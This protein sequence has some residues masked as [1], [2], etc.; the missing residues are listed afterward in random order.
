M[1]DVQVS[2]SSNWR[3]QEIPLT[4]R[5]R[6]RA[7]DQPVADELIPGEFLK[8]AGLEIVDARELTL[9]ARRSTMAASTLE[10]TARPEKD[11]HYVLAI[12]HE[13]GALTFHAPS[14][15]GAGRRGKATAEN[16]VR[17]RVE[18]RDAPSGGGRRGLASRII[19]TVL[20]KVVGKVADKALSWFAQ[21][22]ERRTWKKKGLSEGVF[23]VNRG[24]LVN[25]NLKPARAADFGPTGARCLLLIH[26]TFSNATASFAGLAA[27][28]RPDF[29]DEIERVYD[30]RIFAFNHF[31]VSK[32]PRD[33]VVDLLK[34]LPARSHKFDVITHSRGGLV[35]RTLTEMTNEF[36]DAATR[37]RLGHAVLVAAPN[38][39]TP[40]ATPDRWENYVSWMANVA[41]VLPDNPLS[42]TMDFVSEA[43]S[44]L[45]KRIPGAA[46]GVASM[47]TE[48]P[49]IAALQAPPEPGP[50]AYSALASNYEP[51]SGLWQRAVDVGVDSFF[52]QA[53]DLVVPTE[54]GWIVSDSESQHI[55][56]ERIG[57]YGPGGNLTAAR[58]SNVWHC[59]FFEQQRSRDFVL[60]MLTR[61]GPSVESTVSGPPPGT[62]GVR[63]GANR[64]PV[65]VNL[66]SSPRATSDEATGS[67]TT[68]AASPD[69]QTGFVVGEKQRRRPLM[70][71]VLDIGEGSTVMLATFGN[72]K[73]VEPFR[74][75]GEQQNAG[76]QFYEI[77]KTHE[78]INSYVNGKPGFEL[79]TD[80][81]LIDY[82]KVLFETL[83]PGDVRRL[84][85]VARSEESDEPLD[86]ILTSMTPWIADKPWEFAYDPARKTYLA[87]EEMY[88]TRNVVTSVPAQRIPPKTSKLRILVVSAHPVGT[89]YLSIDQEIAVIRRGFES[90]IES[91]IADVEILA[92][93][94]AGLL[95]SKVSTS[96]YD[97]VHFI[98]HGVYDDETDKGYL[99]FEDAHGGT[100][101]L[102]D[103]ELREIL[104]R[105]SIRLVF[106]NACES[107]K[108]GRSD[109]NRGV[110]P[111]LVA[112]GV[113]TVI[114]NQYSVLDVSATVFAQSLY[115]SLARGQS[116]GS[117]AKEARVC[118]NYS[119][120]GESIDW[121]VPV[122]YTRNP[123]EVLCSGGPTIP[124]GMEHLSG[125]RV[126]RR[127][128]RRAV[129]VGVWDISNQFPDI[130]DL[131]AEMNAV[132]DV[133]GFYCVYLSAPLG[134]I[135]TTE[136]GGG[137]T[138]YLHAENVA[139][140]LKNQ[141]TELGVDYLCCITADPMMDSEWLNLYGWWD[142]FEHDSGVIFFSTAGF[143]LEPDE[144]ATRRILVNE[145]TTTVTHMRANLDTHKRGPKT[146]PFYF[147]EER[148]RS[149]IENATKFDAKCKARLRERLSTAEFKA[150][151][152][153][154]KGFE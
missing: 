78:H 92:S 22:W 52:A 15:V 24:S 128:K 38:N 53:N 147:N 37:F 54:G 41:E 40:L 117:A 80:D 17:F 113:P 145:L 129:Q 64:P 39:G 16:E 139:S 55:P 49:T 57:C 146:C 120:S 13:S 122:V 14:D 56:S 141:P 5:G 132:Q 131:L 140:R 32:T 93:A 134:A 94:T 74:T 4:R 125:S 107:G 7:S 76:R 114:A 48:G 151:E 133:F 121:A 149:V 144:T 33:N 67:S 30:G 104:C 10:L 51:D 42:L 19:K 135:T 46:P 109:F 153:L 3:S 103:R 26:G 75:K 102:G 43:V 84:Y 72:A 35:L 34:A 90:L 12:R 2:I 143:D 11:T 150:I 91:G 20:L 96:E 63:R 61:E 71:T 79:P 110:A 98:G 152:T 123:Q 21:R 126:Q 58:D 95:H 127:G 136:Q 105:R 29:F 44:W 18:I 45:A 36:G 137:Q 119:I 25:G 31:T 124:G 73:V 116:I 118:V 106:L 88:F 99:L 154:Y 60:S 148:D 85:D 69:E 115:W 27:D 23:L 81:E 112:G 65:R 111:A 138:R 100:Q 66:P 68:Y 50:T 89:G 142:Y 108:G 1:S 97:V 77:I 82:G 47:D 62:M 83:F 101:R 28:G 59:D 9:D 6:R 70:L 8:P 130:E 86:V 87:T